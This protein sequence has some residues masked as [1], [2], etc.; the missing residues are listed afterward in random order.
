MANENTLVFFPLK[1]QLANYD[2]YLCG[3]KKLYLEILYFSLSAIDF[4]LTL[5]DFELL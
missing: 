4:P 5:K 3:E 2:I 1:Q